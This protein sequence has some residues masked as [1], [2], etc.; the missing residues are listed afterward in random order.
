MSIRE[1]DLK[2]KFFELIE[3]NREFKE[4]YDEVLED[5][6]ILEK[7]FKEKNIERMGSLW[8]ITRCNMPRLKDYFNDVKGII[9]TILED[10][11]LE[12]NEAEKKISI[13]I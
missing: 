13:V 6:G 12:R 3:A 7:Y 9:Y 8:I 4:K 1:E 11:K 5:I 10:L 2:Y